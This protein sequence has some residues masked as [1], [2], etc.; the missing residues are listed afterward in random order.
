MKRIIPA[1]TLALL[2]ISSCQQTQTTQYSQADAASRIAKSMIGQPYRYGGQSPGGFDC[3]GL[4]WYSYKKVGVKTARTTKDLRK[5]AKK[6]SRRKLRA[7]DLVFF[8]GW[9]RTGHVGMYIATSNRRAG[10]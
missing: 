4:V 10:Y 7:G 5:Q 6:I 3:S 9:V 1:L 2:L 8:K